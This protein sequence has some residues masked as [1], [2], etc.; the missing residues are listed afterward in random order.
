[1]GFIANAAKKVVKKTVVNTVKNV[2]AHETIKY[3]DKNHS[4]KGILEKNSMPN[5]IVVNKKNKLINK[6]YLVC[7]ET[8]NI[9]YKII[10]N[11]KHIKLFNKNEIEKAKVIFNNNEKR[12]H[13]YDLYIDGEK[14]GIVEK[15][16]T[17]KV[18][19]DLKF[20]NWKVEGNIMQNDYNVFDEEG[21]NV[22][23]LHSAYDENTQIIEYINK[24]DELLGILIL[25]V[26]ELIYE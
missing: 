17:I 19:L 24:D 13:H 10:K 12:I 15:Q 26:L 2:A 23:K 4:V 7:D 6:Q 21:Y 8:N 20:N 25:M 1:M 22:I 18:K 16:N 9:I 5:K 14:L 3:M 11:K